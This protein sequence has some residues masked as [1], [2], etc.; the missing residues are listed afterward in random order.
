M[1][2]NE[3]DEIKK[4]KIPPYTTKTGLQIGLLYEEKVNQPISFDMELI[5]AAYLD[6]PTP[7]RREKIKS[8][9]YAAGVVGIVICLLLVT[10]S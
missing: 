7:I 2:E 9:G 4:E 10:K 6:D 5:Q 8:I 3:T 1:L